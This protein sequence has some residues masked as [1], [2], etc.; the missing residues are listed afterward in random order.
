[1]LALGATREG[2]FQACLQAVRGSPATAQQAAP[3]ASPVRASL[4]V[5]VRLPVPMPPD[6]AIIPP[7][8]GV[9]PERAAFSGVWVGRW[10]SVQDTVLTVQEIMPTAISALYG[11]GM[12]PEWRV[13]QGGWTRAR[14]RFVGAELHVQTALLA[15]YRMRPDG[16][17]DGELGIEGRPRAIMTRVFP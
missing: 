12:A 11:W 3:A 7:G 6:L 16:R 1:M 2:G 4:P 14:A 15:I 10:D 5:N 17:L 8:P 9:P 13:A